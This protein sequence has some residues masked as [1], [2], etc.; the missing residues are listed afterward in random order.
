[1]GTAPCGRSKRGPG[2]EEITQKWRFSL[3]SQDLFRAA[4]PS[5]AHPR[6][7]PHLTAGAGPAA[8]PTPSLPA[9]PGDS[10]TGPGP[11]RAP[12]PVPHRRRHRPPARA[13]AHSPAPPRARTSSLRSAAP[14]AAPALPAAGA[15]FLPDAI[16]GRTPRRREEARAGAAAM[17]AGASGAGIR[18]VRRDS[19]SLGPPGNRPRR[20]QAT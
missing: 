19:L 6:E 5:A 15:G 11:P 9:G 20:L 18:A 16:E 12:R 13:R 4:W 14:S 3:H 7:G 8:V 10:G 1:M 17:A 2:T